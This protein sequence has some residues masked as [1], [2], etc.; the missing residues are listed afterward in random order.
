MTKIQ[1]AIQLAITK[2]GYSGISGQDNNWAGCHTHEFKELTLRYPGAIFNDSKFWQA[3]GKAL[4][5]DEING[6]TWESNR[7]GFMPV[8]QHHWHRFIDSLI[9]GKSTEDFFQELIG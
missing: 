5:W 2:G 1:E 8:W 7:F 3:L 6:K 4:G 9:A